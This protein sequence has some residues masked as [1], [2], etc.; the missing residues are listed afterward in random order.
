VKCRCIVVPRRVT[1]GFTFAKDA[2]STWQGRQVLIVRMEASSPLIAALVNPLV[3]T[4]EQAPPHRV[5]LYIGRTTPKTRAGSK[6]KDL[7]GVTVF[8]W[9]SAR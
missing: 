7:D 9:D 8:D 2:A 5:L 4:I 1:V 6:W 3:F